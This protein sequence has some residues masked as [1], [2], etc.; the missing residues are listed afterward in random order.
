VLGI[1][2]DQARI[3]AIIP[4]CRNNAKPGTGERAAGDRASLR[5]CS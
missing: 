5:R 2:V 4:F 3:Q 1:Q